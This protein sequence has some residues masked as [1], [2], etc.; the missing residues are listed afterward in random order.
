MSQL[1][2]S[3][4]YVDMEIDDFATFL[5]KRNVNNAIIELSLGGVENNK[6]LFLFLVDLVCKGLVLLFGEDNRVEL[7]AV[8]LDD[9]KL[10]AKKLY[11]A[12]ISVDLEVETNEGDLPGINLY[13]IE[14]K[15]DDL[16][17]SEFKFKI[18]S[19][20]FTYKLGFA[21]VHRV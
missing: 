17:L 12:G 6:D 13:E 1:S 10:I 14:N 15:P 21:L 2:E 3:M 11:C 16:P 4:L 8:T 18:T 7:D 5:F 19:V 20:S 9:F